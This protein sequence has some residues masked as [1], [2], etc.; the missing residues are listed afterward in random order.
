MCEQLVKGTTQLRAGIIL[1]ALLHG[2]L[3]DGAIYGDTAV[4]ELVLVE[5]CLQLDS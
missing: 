1:E 4:R 5:E 2:A 3:R